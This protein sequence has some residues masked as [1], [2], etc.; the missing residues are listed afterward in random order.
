MIEADRVHSTPLTNTSVPQGAN[1]PPDARADSVR[2]FSHQAAV[3]NLTAETSP[4]T[5]QS[6]LRAYPAGLCLPG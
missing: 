5:L 1:S 6:P 4:A 2:A 3:G